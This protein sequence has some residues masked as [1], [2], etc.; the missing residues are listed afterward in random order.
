MR[1]Q[2][3]QPAGHLEPHPAPRRQAEALRLPAVSSEATHTW[4]GPCERQGTGTG[5]GVQESGGLPGDSLA[6]GPRG[7]GRSSSCN[8]SSNPSGAGSLAGTSPLAA[9]GSSQGRGRLQ[10]TSLPGGPGRAGAGHPPRAPGCFWAGCDSR[11]APPDPAPWPGLPPP[12]LLGGPRSRGA[13]PD[14]APWPGLPSPAPPLLRSHE[15]T[16]W[17]WDLLSCKTRLA[18]SSRD[19]ADSSTVKGG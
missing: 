6:T 12:A 11:G 7:R 15:I 17:F 8:I 1:P 9:A 14:P 4:Q 2:A 18:A 16:Q 5:T 19:G 13:P 3:G 10:A